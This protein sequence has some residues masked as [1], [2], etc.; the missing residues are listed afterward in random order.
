MS[1][2]QLRA[3]SK[4]SLARMARRHGIPGSHAM[5]KEQLVKALAAATNGRRSAKTKRPR[6][7][8][9]KT[10]PA[11]A[12]SQKPKHSGNSNG[13]HRPIEVKHSPKEARRAISRELPNRYGRDRIVLMVRDPYWL[14][15]YWE[16][17]L[18]SVQRAEAALREEWHG[19]KPILRVFDVTSEDT[20]SAAEAIVRDIDIHGGVSNWYIDVNNPPRSYRVDIGYLSQ[21]GRFYTLAH[22]NVVTTPRAGVSDVIDEN[23]VSVQE[24]FEKIYALSGG[25]DPGASSLE[26]KQLLHDRMKRPIGSIS[27]FSLGAISNVRRRKFWFELDAELIV[28]GSTQPGARVQLQGEPIQ[29]RPDGTF[30]MRFRLPDKRLIIPACASSADGAEERTIVLAVERNT[31]ALEPL[32]HDNSDL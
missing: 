14:H 10:R 27:S 25:L 23:W 22:S 7:P 31:K 19:S 21:R 2:E 8:A 26:L 24:Q 13:H 29:V 6:R 4:E 32:L 18:S 5:R 15:A 20:T 11:A 17:N 9:R 3:R 1:L 12:R 16:I 28:H 30:T